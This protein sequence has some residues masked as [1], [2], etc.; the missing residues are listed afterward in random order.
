MGI[1]ATYPPKPADITH[2]AIFSAMDI[3]H[4][5]PVDRDV[6]LVAYQ[7]DILLYLRSVCEKLIAERDQAQRML[8]EERTQA[9]LLD[10]IAR[11]LCE[12]AMLVAGVSTITEL[13]GAILKRNALTK[14]ELAQR[15]KLLCE[16]REYAKRAESMK[17]RK[18]LT[19]AERAALVK[20]NL[21]K[22]D[23]CL[24]RALILLN[25]PVAAPTV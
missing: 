12:Q 14:D 7:G 24:C 16:S 10:P 5:I 11:E 20:M 22:S 1:T 25:D 19:S 8:N 13:P 15:W 9:P 6:N 18:N 23:D 3:L 21:E 17:A 2:Q 4:A